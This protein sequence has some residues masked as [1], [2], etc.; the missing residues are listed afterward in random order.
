M[1]K[2]VSSML[3]NIYDLFLKKFKA[4]LTTWDHFIEFI[5]VDNQGSLFFEIPHKFEWLFEDQDLCKTVLDIYDSKLLRSDY[6]DHLGELYFKKV[7]KQNDK[8]ISTKQADT[9]ILNYIDKTDKQIKI[10][11]PNCQT[12]RVIMAV[13]DIANKAMIYAI[14]PDIRL[15]RIALTNMIIHNIKGYILCT[16]KPR[17]NVDDIINN[18]K[19]KWKYANS[20]CVP[21]TQLIQTVEKQINLFPQKKFPNDMIVI[22]SGGLT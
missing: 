13:K 19:N 10:L 5:A 20:W 22:N 21:S 6:Y 18:S 2:D 3:E 17:S 15:Y 12:G 16:N 1:N 14:E 8:L 11:I 4:E 7:I 9:I